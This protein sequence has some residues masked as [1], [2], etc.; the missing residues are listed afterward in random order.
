MTVPHPS[1]GG[2]G[3]GHRGGKDAYLDNDSGEIQFKICE[4]KGDL[5]KKRKITQNQR[6]RSG[7]GS[8]VTGK[9]S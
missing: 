8:P 9:K 3:G 2:R 7:G 6:E 5:K 4:A 1:G